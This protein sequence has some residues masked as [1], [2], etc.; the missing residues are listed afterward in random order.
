MQVSVTFRN[1]ESNE[2]MREYVLEK[3]SKLRKY[4]EVP[5]EASVVLSAEKH[6]QTAEI[7][8]SANGITLNAQDEN[9]EMLAAI[10]RVMDKLER[11]ILKHKEKGRQHKPNAFHGEPGLRSEIGSPSHLTEETDWKIMKTKT[12]T[13][14]LMSV[15]EAILQMEDLSYNFVI[16]QNASSKDL[17]I[18]YR[19]K[20]G[21][22]G[23]IVPQMG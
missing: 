23:L 7:T 21:H 18:L 5:L 4:L 17:N 13:V 9:E 15:E 2:P 12:L 8:L 16:F 3:I 19:L 11:Q 22:Y 10:D 14:P 20:D 6:R 1:M